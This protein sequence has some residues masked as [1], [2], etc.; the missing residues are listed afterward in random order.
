MR[1]RYGLLDGVEILRDFFLHDTGGILAA[2]Q[3]HFYREIAEIEG[4][5]FEP[6]D[7]QYVEMRMGAGGLL[8]VELAGHGLFEFDF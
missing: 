6:G 1:R 7:I 5:V 2:G 8:F 3:C 4:R